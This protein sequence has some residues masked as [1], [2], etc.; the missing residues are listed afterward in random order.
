[1]GEIGGIEP[2]RRLETL[3]A[4][5]EFAARE[6]GMKRQLAVRRIDCPG[7]RRRIPRCGSQ[8][9][10]GQQ[11]QDACAAARRHAYDLEN[12]SMRRSTPSFSTKW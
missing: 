1:M 7:R 5:C 3:E 11:R 4:A 12:G 9:E 6:P 10:D 2:D 8:Y